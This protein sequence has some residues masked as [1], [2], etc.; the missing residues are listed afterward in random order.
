MDTHRYQNMDYAT[1]LP[2][3]VQFGHSP[4]WGGSPPPECSQSAGQMGVPRFVGFPDFAPRGMAGAR[5]GACFE[6]AGACSAFC[7]EGGDGAVR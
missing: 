2:R 1:A 4:G 5:S 6:R 3:W 7:P